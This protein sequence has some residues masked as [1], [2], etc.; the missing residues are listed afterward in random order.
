[1]I[2]DETEYKSMKKLCRNEIF[3]FTAPSGYKPSE[4]HPWLKETVNAPH[5]IFGEEYALT[6]KDFKLYWHTYGVIDGGIYVEGKISEDNRLLIS[7]HKDG[8]CYMGCLGR[9]ELQLERYSNRMIEINV[10]ANISYESTYQDG[11]GEISIS[12]FDDPDYVLWTVKYFDYIANRDAFVT[13]RAR[14][15]NEAKVVAWYHSPWHQCQ[16]EEKPIDPMYFDAVPYRPIQVLTR[17]GDKS[18]GLNDLSD[19]VMATQIAICEKYD[20]ERS[21]GSAV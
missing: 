2:D 1:M 6:K 3:Q 5:W 16:N 14:S 20:K 13:V 10:D 11:T 19:A 9:K 7:V 15:A 12:Y 4:K 8:I 18:T 21:D 17:A